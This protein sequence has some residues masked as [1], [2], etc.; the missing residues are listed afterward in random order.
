MY[1]GVDKRPK[2]KEATP[3]QGYPKLVLLSMLGLTLKQRW[4]RRCKRCAKPSAHDATLC[5]WPSC[6]TWSADLTTFDA[7]KYRSDCV[8]KAN[9]VAADPAEVDDS[10]ATGFVPGSPCRPDGVSCPLNCPVCGASAGAV[11]RSTLAACCSPINASGMMWM[12]RSGVGVP[13]L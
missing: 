4:T 7:S 6:A 3:W 1:D 2:N 9:A 11:W 8:G 10:V 5:S 12:L 13:W